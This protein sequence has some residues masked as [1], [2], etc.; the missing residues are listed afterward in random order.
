MKLLILANE[1]STTWMLVNTLRQEYPNLVVALDQPQKKMH[2][3]KRR[4]KKIGLLPVLGQILFMCYLPILKR[5][6]VDR[7]QQLERQ[8]NLNSE[9]PA[10]LEF[11]QFESV[12]SMHC[13][14]WLSAQKPD[15]IVVNGTRIL[16]KDVLEAC[17]AKFINIHCGITPTYRGVHGGYW[18]L[19]CQDFENVGVTIHLVDTGI[20]TGKIVSQ[21]LIDVD[22]NDNF[23]TYPV[24]QY[25]AA[26][27][28]VR[29]AL[30]DLEKNCLET[31]S[32]CNRVSSIWHHPTLLQY[33]RARFLY[34]VK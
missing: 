14:E 10:G 4:I 26:I 29:R 34:G 33:L 1:S 25:A 2:L 9:A 11:I 3:L 13:I 23:L 7:I 5:L 16:S 30:S 31:R 15:I 17:N 22:E 32:G 27:P 8:Y 6:S 24:K 19:Y 28:L 21:A 20:D 18:A 12:N